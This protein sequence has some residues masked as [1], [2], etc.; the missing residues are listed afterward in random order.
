MQFW[1]E[2]I[3]ADIGYHCRVKELFIQTY[4]YFAYIYNKINTKNKWL[5]GVILELLLQ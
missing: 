5:I 4:L 3:G 1:Y 2:F